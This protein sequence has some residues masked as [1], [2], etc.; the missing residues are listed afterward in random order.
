MRFCRSVTGLPKRV[1]NSALH[2]AH[3]AGYGPFVTEPAS[4]ESIV[5]RTAPALVLPD[6]AGGSFRLNEHLER[7]PVVLFFFIHNGTPG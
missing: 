4:P 6:S 2:V 7:G 3:E 5:G 1:K